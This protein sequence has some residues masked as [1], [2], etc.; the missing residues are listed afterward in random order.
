M[1]KVVSARRPSK[2]PPKAMR[3][4]GMTDV[5]I[6]GKLFL[7]GTPAQLIDPNSLIYAK[8]T[9]IELARKAKKR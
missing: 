2:M 3:R 5:T 7:I 4:K 1:L 6:A 8:I 9:G